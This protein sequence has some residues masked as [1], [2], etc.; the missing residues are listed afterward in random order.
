MASEIEK[1][2]ITVGSLIETLKG[3]PAEAVVVLASD[4][5]GNEFHPL[6][7]MDPVTRWDPATGEPVVYDEMVGVPAIFLFPRHR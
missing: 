6:E 3:Q 5:E 2:Y 4:A 7:G 1:K